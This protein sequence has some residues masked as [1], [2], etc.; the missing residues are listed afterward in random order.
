MNLQKFYTKMRKV[1]PEW[2]NY[3]YSRRI[4]TFLVNDDHD[5][6]QISTHGAVITLV[7]T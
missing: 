6:R 3:P 5:F 1:C 7:A 4:R 2:L